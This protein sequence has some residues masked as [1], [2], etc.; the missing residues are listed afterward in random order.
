LPVGLA[1]WVAAAVYVH[2]WV[3]GIRIT[4]WKWIGSWGI[5]TLA[6][7]AATVVFRGIT[8]GPLTRSGSGMDFL[9]VAAAIG[10][11][12]ATGS[13]GLFAISRLNT[14]DDERYLRAQLAGRS[15]YAVEAAVLLSGALAAVLYRYWPGAESRRDPVP[16][17]R[18]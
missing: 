1:G 2:A 7:L 12:L 5:V 17:R 14:Y 6:S 3:R 9:G 11:F 16:L 18:T 4:R 8:G 13:A 10:V 15:F